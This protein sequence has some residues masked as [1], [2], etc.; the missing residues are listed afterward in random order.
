MVTSVCGSALKMVG[1]GRTSCVGGGARLRRVI[2]PNHSGIVQSSELGSITG[3]Q[4]G[5][6][7]KEFANGSPRSRVY[8]RWLAAEV[9]RGRAHCS[10]GVGSW[11]KLGKLHGLSGKLS[12][13]SGED[14]GLRK[15]LATAAM[16]GQWW[17]AVALASRGELR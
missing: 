6:R 13:G 9:R 3:S 14:G 5:C 8:V 1:V 12:K 11:L 10:G 17:R 15:R 16:L 7:R 4:G 2:R